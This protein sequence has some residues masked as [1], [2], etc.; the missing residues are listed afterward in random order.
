MLHVSGLF[1]CDVHNTCSDP[2]SPT[3]RMGE[4]HEKTA[5]VC[6]HKEF[7]PPVKFYLKSW[8]NAGNP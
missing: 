5:F 4:K 7:S 3:N 2:L 1:T 6:A 8:E